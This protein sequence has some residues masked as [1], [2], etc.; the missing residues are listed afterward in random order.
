M[1]IEAIDLKVFKAAVNDDTA[2]NG[3]AMSAVEA[4]NGAADIW[5]AVDLAER[6]AGS[7]RYR[8]TFFK[9]HN[10]EDIALQNAVVGLSKP[11]PGEDAIYLMAADQ[12]NTQG[13]LLGTED[14]YGAGQLNAP[15]SAG[16]SSIDVLVEDGTVIVFRAGERIRVNSMTGDVIK[17]LEEGNTQEFHTINGTP[18]VLGDVVTIAI[19]GTLTNA[20]ATANTFVSSVI[21]AGAVAGTVSV[22]AV[23][24]TAGVIDEALLGLHNVGAVQETWTLTFTSALNYDLVGSSLG[25]IGSGSI[26]SDYAPLNPDT[27]TPYL[28]LTAAFFS[29]TWVAGDTVVMATSPAAVPVFEERVVP[30]GAASSAGNTRDLF[31]GGES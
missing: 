27:A 14:R 8:K 3:G 24:S 1:A 22:P 18:T 16:G 12:I 25:A 30:I 4:I 21:E 31:M 17:D 26:S 6:L 23:T 9:N 19:T 28:T 10:S 11:T 2:S 13:D 7:T 15:L 29:G 5:P 20:Y